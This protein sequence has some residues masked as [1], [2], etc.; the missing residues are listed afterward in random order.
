[1]SAPRPGLL[2]VTELARRLLSAYGYRSDL[3][4]TA[5]G[6]VHLWSAPGRG[7]ASPV[8]V[9][10]GLGS[11]ALNWIPVLEQLR[12]HVQRVYAVDLPGHGFSD[13]P[14]ELTEDLL[15]DGLLEGL[16]RSGHA[17]AL[18]VGHSLGGAAAL[19]YVNAR[20]DRARGLLLFSPAGAPLSPEELDA[21]RALFTVETYEDAVKFLRV[22]HARPAELRARVAAPFVRASLR[23]PQLRSWLSTVAPHD[24]QAGSIWLDPA[25]IRKL[26]VPLR[27]VWGRDDRILPASALAFW[28]AHLPPGA[29]LFEPSG[30]GHTP[31]LDD[32][33]WTVSQ[34]R[35]CAERE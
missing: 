3:V 18:V 32:R 34:I 35:A 28:R 27:V 7:S 15:R 22:L 33:T 12:P 6:R 8:L 26:S 24:G 10:H 9:I 21:V 5:V 29:E 16:E 1:V 11:A 13:K 31:F 4:P 19:R 25:E 23:D 20:P 14:A 30:I 2:A 17:R